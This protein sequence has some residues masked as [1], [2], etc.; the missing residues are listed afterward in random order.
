MPIGC[1]SRKGYGWPLPVFNI[2]DDLVFCHYLNGR[3][4]FLYINTVL[5]LLYFLALFFIIYTLLKIIKGNK[6]EK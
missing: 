4:E 2:L 1:Y 5:D 6:E 3:F